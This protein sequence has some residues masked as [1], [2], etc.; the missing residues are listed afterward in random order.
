[1]KKLFL[2]VFSVIFLLAILEIF[3]RFLLQKIYNRNFD[4]SL[5][6]E[7]KFFS[8]DGLKENKT[9]KVWGKN[10][11]TDEFGCRKNSKPFDNKKK[12]W[13]FIGDSVTQGVGV[14]DSCTF[15]SLISEKIDSLNILNYSHIGY[16]TSDYDNVLSSILKNDSEVK[17][18]TIFFCLNDVYG[19][20]KT[21]ELP[22]IAK[23]NLLG[24]L[25]GF[26][27]NKYA[28]YKMIKLIAFQ[29]ANRY[30]QY[31]AKFYEP[32]NPFF[33]DAMNYLEKCKN[34]CDEKNVV[35][36]LVVLPYRSQLSEDAPNKHPQQLIKDFCE[37]KQITFF[38][39]AEFLK[40]KSNSKKLYLFSD[41]IHFSEEGHKAI[42]EFLQLNFKTI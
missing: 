30:F 38:D 32:G 31:D 11:R 41:E 21:D 18:V 35:M 8:S 10:F 12:K 9:G 15:S 5:I 34:L 1:M 17:L 42:A 33:S 24:K 6:I 16:S 20:A 19:S 26:F 25:N 27:Q 40:Q 37:K 14:N 4:S 39:A 3:S 22:V 28:T 7:K 23:Q 29:N 13:L 2:L 36:N